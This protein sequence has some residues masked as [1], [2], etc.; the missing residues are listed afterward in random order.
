MLLVYNSSPNFYS[1]FFNIIKELKK[2]EKIERKTKVINL[3]QTYHSEIKKWWHN[4]WTTNIQLLC[5]SFLKNTQHCSRNLIKNTQ[6]GI[7]TVI[8]FS[9]LWGAPTLT[10]FHNHEALQDWLIC[11][12]ILTIASKQLKKHTAKES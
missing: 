9:H 5:N 8:I 4:V 3:S 10:E 12:H 11:T 6:N 2:E 7:K 1:N